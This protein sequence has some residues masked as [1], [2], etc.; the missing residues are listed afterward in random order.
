M[1]HVRNRISQ[2]TSNNNELEFDNFK[3]ALNKAA[4]IK[5]GYVRANKVPFI[6]K[7]ISKEIRKKSR[8][9]NNF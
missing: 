9:I 1:A 3:R 8:L 4:S 7:K 2:V 5:Q 6:N